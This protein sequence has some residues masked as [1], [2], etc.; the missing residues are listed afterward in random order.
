MKIC[1]KCH[2]SWQDDFNLC[3]ICGGELLP[4]QP[5]NLDS[6]YM[7]DG[8]AINGGIH[9][10]KDFSSKDDHSV[11]SSHNISNSNNNTTNYSSKHIYHGNYT[12]VEREKSKEEILIERKSKFREYCKEALNDGLL[13]REER[14]WLNEQRSILGLSAEMADHILNDVISNNQHSVM[15]MGTVQ[16]IQF[17]NFK[18]AIEGNMVDNI[19]KYMPQIKVIA[20]KFQEEELQ[21]LYHLAL[22]AL[23]PEECVEVYKN[24]EEDKYW[25][26]FWVY[27]ALYKLGDVPNA[28]NAL[29]DLGRWQGLMPDENLVILGAFGA[30]INNDKN[31]ATELFNYVLTGEC[32]H[33]LNNMAEVISAIINYHPDD[34]DVKTTLVKHRFYVK[35]FLENAY[36]SEVWILK[37]KEEEEKRKKEEARRKAEEEARIKAE[38]EAKRKQE[39]E[40]RRRKEREEQRQKEEAERVRKE[41]EELARRKAAEEARKKAEAE[42]RLKIEEEKKRKEKEEEERRRKEREEQRQK[43]EAERVRKE[44]EELA[45]RRAVEAEMRRKIEEEKRRMQEEAD[46]KA[47]EAEEEERRRRLDQYQQEAKRK[48]EEMRKAEEEAGRRPRFCN[49]CGTQIPFGASFCKS[50]GTKAPVLPT[51]SGG[52]ASRVCPKCNNSAGLDAKFCKKCGYKF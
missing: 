43:E 4:E 1:S 25:L 11:S 22:A 44:R 17:N 52:I 51:N 8:N 35:H 32:S 18:R 38:K 5:K 2:K 41:R 39:E 29:I 33:L 42:L 31:T 9:V 23:N 37:Q 24:R 46:R 45:R 27:V 16:R 40:E 49:K 30:L 36:E 47:K 13:T 7:G 6:I 48:A 26:T 15:S 12:H 20:N 50:C 3:P 14:N 10:S 21:F 28:E 19:K 34:A